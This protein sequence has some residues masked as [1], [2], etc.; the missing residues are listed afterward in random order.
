MVNLQNARPGDTKIVFTG[1]MG[2]GKTTA[3]N[4]VS[5]SRVLS[6]EVPISDGSS[7]GAKSH[8]T[9]GF[10][11]GECLLDDGQSLRLFGTPGQERFRFMWDIIGAGAFGLVVLIDNS[12]PDPIGDVERYLEAF[13]R[14]IP[15][16]RTV[17]GVGRLED[18]PSPSIE[19]YCQRLAANHAP[20]PVIDV[21]VRQADDVR[22]LLSV[23]VSLVEVQHE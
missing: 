16:E 4:A 5:D 15:R 23:L 11:Y 6:T 3:I 7:V 10:D 21:D 20:V 13:A 22:L 8:T 9:V 2:A 19:D 17:I 1:P 14:Q 18:A 12:R